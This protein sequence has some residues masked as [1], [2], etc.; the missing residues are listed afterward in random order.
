MANLYD[1][2]RYG[3]VA[4]L[5]I[6]V[7]L[8]VL[9]LCIS[10]NIVKSL[11]E[12]ERQRM[13][14]W[15]DAT[16]AIA[17]PESSPDN[18]DFLL[19]II[20]SNRNIPVLLTD[21]EGNILDQRN[22]DLPEPPDTLRPLYISPTNEAFLNKR[23]K[24]LRHTSNVIVIDI[25]GGESQYLYYE[26]SRLLRMLG[27]YP[28]IQVVVMLVFVALVYFAVISTKKAEQ[29]KVWVG[30]TKE[31]A[32][33][34][35]TPISS[36]MAWMELLQSLGV[37]A[38][39][40]AEMNKDVTRLSTIASRF[41]KVGSRPTL[42][43]ADLN[44]VVADAASYMST[45]ISSR[46]RLTVDCCSGPLMVNLSDSLFQWVMENLIKNA[47]DAMDA[48][49]SITVTTG[50]TDRTAWIEVADTGKGLPRNRFKTIFNPGYTTKKRGWGLG[51]ALARRIIEQYHH[52]RIYVAASEPGRGTTFRID[53]PIIPS[54][55][56]S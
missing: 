34:L 51:L 29:N 17:N 45:R 11:A 13:E 46:I 33:Q 32:H 40:V 53:L 25:P 4:F 2:R 39:T 54:V 20:R 27:H 14:I 47:V 30:L 44:A 43:P 38:D 31:T 8:A 48:E 18:I 10:D 28:Y 12:Q 5:L 9:F 41:G 56:A 24:S 7:G 35:G 52:G 42:E 23:L 49:G 6:A 16:K 37:D 15:A 36:L 22:F 3:T 21:R 1:M 50:H 26:D 19:S 55:S